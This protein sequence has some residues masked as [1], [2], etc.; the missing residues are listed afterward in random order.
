MSRELSIITRIRQN[1][2]AC[3]SLG[4]I[5]LLII[6]ALF[7]YVIAPDSTHNANS[8]LS[9]LALL[10]PGT[11]IKIVEIEK[12]INYQYLPWYE[13][14]LYGNHDRRAIV[15]YD[16]LIWQSSELIIYYQGSQKRYS[17]PDILYAVKS[18]DEITS[19]GITWTAITED[20]R[21][22]GNDTLVEEIKRTNVGIKTYWLGSDKYGRDTLS[23]LLIG[24]RAS[25]IIGFLAVLVSLVIGI[26]IGSI[27]GYYGGW[28]DHMLMLIINT[29]WSIP[30]LLMAFA[31]IL[32]FGKG[33]A[34]IVLSV[35]LTM[36]VDVARIV[37]GQVMQIKEELYVKATMIMGL[38]THQT[39]IYHIL[40]NILGPILVIA[41]ANFA[42]AVLVEA[43]LSYLGIGIQPPAPSLGNMLKESYA[44]AAGG[45]VYLVIF[46]IIMI[47]TLVLVFNILG[48]AL[49]DVF[50]IKT[51]S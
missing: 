16:S 24:L 20:Q 14:L 1:K 22:A 47:M 3:Y 34:V 43:G 7:A 35:G 25:L 18:I 5:G 23:R 17:Y 30:T 11:S 33:F 38:P 29:A 51:N 8:Q 9:E 48:T 19:A 32:A 46:P 26:F 31:V 10:T 2:M 12:N 39:I 41:A 27:A 42:A 50:D 6:I 44:Y 15:P 4:L 37:R 28:I 13:R 45:Y 36:W 40:P 49:R 21:S